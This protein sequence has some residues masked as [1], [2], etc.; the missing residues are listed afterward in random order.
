LNKKVQKHPFHLVTPSPWPLFA[1]VATLLITLGGV[2]YMHR[3]PFG[4]VFLFFGVIYLLGIVGL[5]WRDVIRESTY[6]GTHTLRVQ[7][8][9]KIGMLLFI[10]SEVLFFFAF[11]W[12]FFHSSLAPSV[13]IGSIWPP[14]G[15]QAFDPWGIP[16]LN[17]FILLLSGITI[18]YTHHAL[19]TGISSYVIDGFVYTIVLAIIF[20]L[21]QLYEYRNAP[22]NISDGIYGSTFYLATGFHGLHVLIGTAFITVCFARYTHFTSQHHVGFEAAAWYWHFVDVVWLF[23]FVSIYFWGS[24]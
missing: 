13:E 3:F 16:L 24:L 18:T 19:I 7:R 22:F 8:G 15:I 14:V 2:M 23:L 9:L 17:T 10:I 1:S 6:E 5:W 4:G 21:F 12:A 20:T 11:F